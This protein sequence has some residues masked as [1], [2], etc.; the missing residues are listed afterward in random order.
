MNAT[1]ASHDVRCFFVLFLLTI[2]TTSSIHAGF[3]QRPDG[4]IVDPIMHQ[5]LGSPHRYGGHLKP[6]ANLFSADLANADLRDVRGGMDLRDANL[7][8]VA[9]DDSRFF[10]GDAEPADMNTGYSQLSHTG[11]VMGLT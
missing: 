3:Y 5:G 4:M 8:A 9:I 7:H 1:L 10:G 2:L 6:D 11:G